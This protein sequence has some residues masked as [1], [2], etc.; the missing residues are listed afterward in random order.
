[1]DC[2]QDS[3]R[4]GV[5]SSGTQLCWPVG[6][7]TGSINLTQ[8]LT[9]NIYVRDVLRYEGAS[10]ILNRTWDP[11]FASSANGEQACHV[12][13]GDAAVPIE[14]YFIPVNSSYQA[15]GTALKWT[16]NSDLVAPAAPTNVQ[17][18]VGDTL[19]TVNWTSAGASD[20]DLVGFALWSNPPAGGILSGSGCSCG[21]GTGSGASSYLGDGASVD[22]GTTTQVCISPDG[23]TYPVPDASNSGVADAGDSG[24]ADAAEAAIADAGLAEVADADAEG[25]TID[26]GLETNA[27][28]DVDATAQNESG[29]GVDEA[30]ATAADASEADSGC[31][32]INVGINA[33]SDNCYSS[34]LAAGFTVGTA[35][36]SVV[37]TDGSADDASSSA[38]DS[39]TAVTS[40]SGLPGISEIA[41]AFKAGEIDQNTATTLTLTGLTNGLIYH[42]VVTSI[43]GFGNVGPASTQTCG[44][45]APVNDFYKTYREADGSPPSGSCTL[46][47]AGIPAQAP[48]T[49]MAF[50]GAF[51]AWLRRR[52]RP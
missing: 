41:P 4:T 17:L 25:G 5:T 36:S 8:Y 26:D 32:I 49:V 14:I 22:A 9:Q 18:Q 28:G 19:L 12:Q 48:V 39:G 33:G 6:L 47:G 46:E 10:T 40:G 42:V 20:P 23:A 7:A 37:D 13:T 21:S 44:S 35:S 52:R 30:G 51:A 34:E 15:N 24:V 11:N 27:D 43:D 50:A 45:P 1:V 29:V 3:Y 2:T 16:L 31:K 38:D